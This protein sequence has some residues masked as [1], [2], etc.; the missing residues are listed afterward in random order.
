MFINMKALNKSIGPIT[1][2]T[3]YKNMPNKVIL[4]LTVPASQY[5]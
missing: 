4:R 1:L 5:E 2:Y 3:V